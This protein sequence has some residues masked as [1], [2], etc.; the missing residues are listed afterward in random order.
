MFE[1]SKFDIGCLMRMLNGPNKFKHLF[2]EM[3][4]GSKFDI[5][6]LMKMLND[7]HLF[8]EMFKVQRYWM[9][10][11]MLNGPKSS[12]ICLKKCLKVQSLILDV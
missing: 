1:G 3:F 11:R 8:K 5:G 9:L 12:N 4:E 7:E 2:K 10:M 6:C